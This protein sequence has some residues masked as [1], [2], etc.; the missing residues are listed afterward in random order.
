MEA[1]QSLNTEPPVP[2]PVKKKIFRRRFGLGPVLIP[3]L[4]SASL[5]LASTYSFAATPESGAVQ[6]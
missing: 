5:L 3:L 6:F 2:L 4:T 1:S